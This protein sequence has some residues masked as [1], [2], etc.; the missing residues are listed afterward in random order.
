MKK[1][2]QNML[3]ILNREITDDTLNTNS[4]ETGSDA[5]QNTEVDTSTDNASIDISSSDIST[6]NSEVMCG[7][8][9]TYFSTIQV[10]GRL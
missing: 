1:I 9:N 4:K 5:R 3:T 10:I 6:E 7:N 8:K 2:L